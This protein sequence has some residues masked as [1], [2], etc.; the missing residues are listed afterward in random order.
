MDIENL[1]GEIRSIVDDIAGLTDGDKQAVVEDVEAA[2]IEA[3]GPD[4]LRA[5]SALRQNHAPSKAEWDAQVKEEES[6]PLCKYCNRTAAQHEADEAATCD[7]GNGGTQKRFDIQHKYK[8]PSA[9][10]VAKGFIEI[11]GNKRMPIGGRRRSMC[12]T[13]RP[14]DYESH[15]AKIVAIETAREMERPSPNWRYIERLEAERKLWKSRATDA[16]HTAQR[17]D[18]M[19]RF[20]WGSVDED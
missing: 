14:G 20:G 18:F 5:L 17:G 10:E 15:R 2:V 12:S 3:I 9:E 4:G 13:M 19:A 7:D 16:I 1:A 11:G 8:A 6:E